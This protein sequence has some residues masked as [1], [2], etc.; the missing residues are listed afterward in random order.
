MLNKQMVKLWIT[1]QVSKIERKKDMGFI[2]PAVA[3]AKIE[4]LRDFYETFKLDEVMVDVKYH[5]KIWSD[6]VDIVWQN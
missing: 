2:K 5:N 6:Q 3:K 1:D 4:I